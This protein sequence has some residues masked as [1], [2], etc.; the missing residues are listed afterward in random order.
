MKVWLIWVVSV[1]D[2]V[3]RYVCSTEEKARKR[4]EDVKKE[5]LKEMEELLSTD[6]EEEE[7][8]IMR[9]KDFERRKSVIDAITFDNWNTGN[10]YV[11][12]KP[13]WECWE[14]E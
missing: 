4:F 10:R 1:S 8:K 12:D 6:Y 5:I 13:Y 11:H 7:Y 2:A 14:V 9:I 3:V